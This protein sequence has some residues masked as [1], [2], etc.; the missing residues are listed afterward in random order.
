[1]LRTPSA[2]NNTNVARLVLLLVLL[3]SANQLFAANT[4]EQTIQWGTMGMSLFGGLALFLFGMEQMSTSL[5]MVA[6]D[7]MKAI[8]ARLTT[9]RFPEH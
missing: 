4:V 2:I 8:L 7:R 3:T 1:M 5:K 6:G 9:N